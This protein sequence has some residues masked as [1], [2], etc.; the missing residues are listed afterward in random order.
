MHEVPQC[1][2]F[3][4]C[5]LHLNCVFHPIPSVIVADLHCFVV[6]A[7][8]D[9]VVM[10]SDVERL[11]ELLL[12]AIARLRDLQKQKKCVLVGIEPTP[13]P[14]ISV[15]TVR[16]KTRATL[17]IVVYKLGAHQCLHPL[18]FVF[19]SYEHP[20]VDEDVRLEL[21]VAVKPELKTQDQHDELFLCLK[22]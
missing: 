6:V 3:C 9:E 15:C 17:W 16:H 21:Q 4:V 8:T 22:Q 2:P 11:T 1:T 5:V 13:V 7:S 12:R 18:S 20:F 14:W 19:L 10:A